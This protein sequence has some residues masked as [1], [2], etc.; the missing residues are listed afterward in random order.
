MLAICDIL[1]VCYGLD[2]YPEDKKF[3]YPFQASL[4]SSSRRNKAM[5]RTGLHSTFGPLQSVRKH[6]ACAL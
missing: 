3:P 1:R 5:E 4:M 6:S 2:W